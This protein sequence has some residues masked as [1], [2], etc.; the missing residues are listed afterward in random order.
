MN[1]LPDL[2][3]GAAFISGVVVFGWLP[4]WQRRMGARADAA[5]DAGDYAGCLAS[6]AQFFGVCAVLM[7]L[8]VWAFAAM[9]AFGGAR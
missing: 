7:A 3:I 9:G 8:A 6:S 1:D 4:G 5:I 2:A